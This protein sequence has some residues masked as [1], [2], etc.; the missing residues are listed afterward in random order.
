MY[1]YSS[2]LSKLQQIPES[3]VYRQSTEA[4]TKQRLSIVEAAIPEGF[5]A[6]QSRIQQKIDS[7]PQVLEVF[8]QYVKKTPDGKVIVLPREVN[9]TDE[10]DL[11]WDGEVQRDHREGPRMNEHEAATQQAAFRSGGYNK[12]LRLVDSLE[13]EAEPS[14]TAQQ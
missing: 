12:N 7:N 3:S 5:E 2:T 14:L 4:L 9:E 1:L 11:E 10:R 6:W 8:G 13:L